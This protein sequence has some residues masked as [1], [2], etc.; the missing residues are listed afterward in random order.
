[1][2]QRE[3]VAGD[4]LA[5]HLLTRA[6]TACKPA[7]SQEAVTAC[8]NCPDSCIQSNHV[9]PT[10]EDHTLEAQSLGE[11]LHC[12]CLASTSRACGGA[13]QVHAEG[14]GQGHVAAVGHGGDHQAGLGSQT[15]L[16]PEVLDVMVV[17]EEHEQV[18]LHSA[19]VF[20]LA[21]NLQQL[22]I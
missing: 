11:V 10:V 4:A 21:E 7:A 6:G 16:L 2:P 20:A 13:P 14:P 19:W 9:V 17:A 15:G 1:M 8:T 12:L 22:I 5:K 3:T 18:W